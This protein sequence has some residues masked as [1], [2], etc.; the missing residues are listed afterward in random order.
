MKSMKQKKAFTLIELMITIAIIAIMAI[1]AVPA[2]NQYAANNEIASKA[3]EI[4]SIIQR[5]YSQGMSPPPGANSAH[6]WI[7]FRSQANGKVIVSKAGNAP[8]WKPLP[9]PAVIIANDN[10]NEPLPDFSPESVT[11]PSHMFLKGSFSDDQINDETY[12]E[13]RSPD[14]FT[15]RNLVKNVDPGIFTLTSTKAPS[16]TY[17]IEIEYSP[18]RVKITKI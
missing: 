8:E 17:T 6:I 12:C 1:L 4:Q 10:P 2:F 13:A 11:L 18:F 16:V 14:K 3:E 15:C 9:S 7:N 5:T